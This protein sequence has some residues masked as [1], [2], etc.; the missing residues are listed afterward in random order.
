M[1]RTFSPRASATRMRAPSDGI[2]ASQRPQG[3]LARSWA[4]LL[5]ESGSRRRNARLPRGRTL[6]RSG[7]VRELWFAPGLANAEVID[8]EPFRVSIRVSVFSDEQW[9]RVV[10]I[11]IDDLANIAELLEGRL[12]R[13]LVERLDAARLSLLPTREEVGGDCECAD[14]VRPCA[15]IAGVHTLLADALDGDPFL[16]FTLRG[17]T[18]EQL[19]SD[20][21]AVW[22]DEEPLRT[23]KE[24]SMPAAAEDDWYG[25][26]S[27]APRLP[28]SFRRTEA[29]AA[30]LKALGPPPGDEDLERALRPLYEGGAAAALEL[31]MAD[32]PEEGADRRRPRARA[33]LGAAG[34]S[35]G[36]E[37]PDFTEV[38]VDALVELDTASHTDL[39]NALKIGAHEVRRE[40]LELEE[41][42]LLVREVG[43]D[44]QNRWRLG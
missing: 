37:E 12:S 10:K 8:S 19:Y 23:V 7:R 9:A 25:A 39:A 29:K 33:P 17:R 35:S 27:P 28:F 38:V 24:R 41:L 11:L 13:T 31:A 3:W 21:R 32:R 14:F 15:H 26:Q 22:G 2:V 34:I 20:L 16:L 6:A 44:G 30:G 42:G 5:R 18:R 43:A 36:T 40:L 4:A 1:T